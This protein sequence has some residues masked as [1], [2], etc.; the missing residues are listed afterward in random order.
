MYFLL[1]QTLN[2]YRMKIIRAAKCTTKFATEKKR[3]ELMVLLKEYGNVVNFFIN[4]FWAKENETLRNKGILLK[5]IVDLP[6]KT[7]WLSAR[8]RKV[9]ARE[10]ID[11]I[12]AV[13]ER[14]KNKPDKISIP[15]HKGE[16]MNCSC[17]IAELIS[18]D[19]HFD[20]FF[21]IRSVGNKM[22]LDIPIKK[23]KLFNK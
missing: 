20:C 14:W 22:K 16:R 9:A 13:R 3:N 7:T 5:P 23:H 17:T 12:I 11:M 8:L 1:T 15:V 4:Y 2:T 21:K 19:G 18:F 10:A 6:I